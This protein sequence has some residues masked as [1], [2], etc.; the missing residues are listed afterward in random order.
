MID[1]L[2]RSRRR[3]ALRTRR[4]LL[5]LLEDRLAPAVSIVYTVTENWGS[6][7]QGQ[8]KLINPDPVP[9]S[10][11]KLEFN[12]AVNLTSVWDAVV[13]S[14][15]GDRYVLQNASWNAMIPAN[16]GSVSFGFVGNPGNLTFGP[17]NYVLNGVPLGGGGGGTPS[18]PSLSVGDI[19]TPEQGNATFTV[20]LSQAS[21]SPV[22]VNY[23][24]S[25]GTATAGSDYTATNGTLTFNPGQTERTI[26][27]PILPDDLY[28]PDETFLLTLSSPSGATLARAQATATILDDD[29]PPASGDFQFRVLNDWGSGFTGEI[30][31]KNSSNTT[32]TDWRIEFDFAGQISDIWNA[33]IA[34]RVGN[35][36]V[37][38]PE[39]WNTSIA[40]GASITFGFVA[41]PGN[42]TT[43]PTN[44]RWVGSSSGG[45]GGGGGGGSQNRAPTAVNDGATTLVNTPIAVAVLVND[46]D[47]DGDPL[48]IQSV[49]QPSSGTVVIQTDGTL[50]FTPANQFVGVVTFG[51]TISDGRGGTASAT[52]TINVLERTS[53]PAQFYAPYVD[54]TLWPTYNFAEVAQTTSVRYFTLAF[55]TADP[56]GRPAWGGYSQY[57]VGGNDTFLTQLDQQIQT[58]RNL[59]GDVMVSFGGAANQE[60]AEVITNVTALKNAYQLV[61]DTYQLTHIDFDIEGAAVA[62]RSSVDRRSQAIAALQADMRAT[63]RELVVSFTLPVLPS[64]LTP[65]GVYVLQSALNHGVEIGGVNIMTMDYGSY[66]APNPQGRMGDYAI[67]AGQ[68][69]HAQ[70]RSVYGSTKTD[71]QLW[72]MIGL[73]PMIG[74]NDVTTEVFDQQ[75]AR[76]VVEFAQQVGINRI[77]MWSLNRDR[78]HPNGEL[79][80]VD[81]FSS[82][83]LQTPLEFSLIFN[84]VTRF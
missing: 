49:T 35:R 21:A 72:A 22:T 24:T 31:A 19:T 55:I 7:F 36:F 71:A 3:A 63:G 6:G 17:T 84:Q 59:G 20:K 78:Q 41:S 75:E 10:S 65:D 43:G 82:S 46:S 73:T 38:R 32:R 76:E 47:P 81:L 66:A 61:I 62:H 9:I 80:Y 11:W 74:M 68:S 4:P 18:L 33:R 30:V 40:P 34:S 57:A 14:R 8:I 48:S 15:T 2:N 56:T 13:Q 29:A 12:F 44:I 1:G 70:M 28:E 27:V 39:S 5:E 25:N 51:Y 45:G 50:R 83:I 37:I 52:V 42:V 16:G 67:E 77:S 60:L 58:V 64:G 23:A 26:A 69:L 79:T 53:W 54:A